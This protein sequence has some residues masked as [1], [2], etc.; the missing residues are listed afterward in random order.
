MTLS[1]FLRKFLIIIIYVVSIILAI[2]PSIFNK[3]GKTYLIENIKCS[4]KDHKI[5]GDIFIIYVVIPFWGIL[6]Y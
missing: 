1:N 2:I 3:V 5:D 4:V 6:I